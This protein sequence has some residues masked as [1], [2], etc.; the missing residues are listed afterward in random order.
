ML[1]IVY[2]F[3]FYDVSVY[4]GGGGGGIEKCKSNSYT[5]KVFIK[6]KNKRRVFFLAFSILKTFLFF[7]G[8][9]L[10]LNISLV[11]ISHKHKRKIVLKKENLC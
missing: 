5:N 2:S 6:I 1:F 7:F 3:H 4:R 9:F 10:S 11:L 8:I